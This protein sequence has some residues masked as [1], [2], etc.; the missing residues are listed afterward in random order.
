[1]TDIDHLQD[2]IGNL[3]LELDDERSNTKL[4][5]D[6]IKYE[7]KQGKVYKGEA[8]RLKAMRLCPHCVCRNYHKQPC[9]CEDDS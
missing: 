7:I 9:H 2:T 6:G 5:E 3:R 4:L 8:E 1:M